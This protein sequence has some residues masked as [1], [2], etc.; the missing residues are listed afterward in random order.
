[1]NADPVKRHKFLTEGNKEN[2]EGGVSGM[3]VRGIG[4]SLRQGNEGQG[5]GDTDFR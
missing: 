5:N 2:E 1:M 4:T 3:F